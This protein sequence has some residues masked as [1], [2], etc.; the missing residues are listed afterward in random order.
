MPGWERAAA[1]AS[2]A[3]LY[4]IMIALPLTGWITNSAAGIPFWFYWRIP[5]PAIVGP[6]KH[7]EELVGFLHV[8]LSLAF[9]A[10]LLLHVAAALRHH[11]A[12]RDGVL[13]RMLPARKSPR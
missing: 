6:D 9:A 2:H 5:V 8:S 13:E 10:L 11:F 1:H 4:L 7:L 12:R 3:L